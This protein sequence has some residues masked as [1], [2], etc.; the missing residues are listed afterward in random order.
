MACHA[1]VG[2]D[3]DLAAGQTAVGVRTTE[4]EVARRVDEHIEVVVRE[5]LGQRRTDDV[6]D[7]RRAQRHV[8][9]MLGRVLGRDEDGLEPLRHTVLVLD[10]H[11]RLAVGPQEVEDAFLAH[12]R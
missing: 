2:V 3:D 1:A 9:A 12:L 11:L 10:R 6:L 5:L 7:Q 4:L 8:D